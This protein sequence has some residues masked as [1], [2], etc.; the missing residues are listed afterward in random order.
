MV[1]REE[2]LPQESLKMVKSRRDLSTPRKRNSLKSRKIIK[3]T[4]R[5]ISA[6]CSAPAI[7]AANIK[8]VVRVRPPNF[9]EQSDNSRYN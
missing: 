3:S 4:T 2:K 8:V 1:L 7:A 9:R 6:S 5:P